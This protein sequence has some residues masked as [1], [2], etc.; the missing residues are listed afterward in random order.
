MLSTWYQSDNINHCLLLLQYLCLIPILL[1]CVLYFHPALTFSG[2]H[3]CLGNFSVHKPTSYGSWLS[4]FYQP[5]AVWPVPFSCLKFTGLINRKLLYNHHKVNF[6]WISSH[7]LQPF[8]SA[9]TSIIPA[10]FDFLLENYH[11]ANVQHCILIYF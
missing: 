5:G 11:F 4:F 3:T 2:C 8:A 7:P 1:Y 6:Q 9:P 10:L